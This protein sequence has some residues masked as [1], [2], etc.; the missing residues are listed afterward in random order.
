[1][2][3]AAH[4]VDPVQLVPPHCPYFGTK[5][6]VGEATAEVD[7]TLVIKVVVAGLVGVLPAVVVGF[8]EPPPEFCPAHFHTISLCLIRPETRETYH[9][10]SWNRIVLEVGVDVDGVAWLIALDESRDRYERAWRA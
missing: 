9:C 7:E 2:L 5:A 1:M 3:P 4:C 8:V 10:R 6:P